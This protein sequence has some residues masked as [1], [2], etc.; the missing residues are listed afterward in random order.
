[1]SGIS[2]SPDRPASKRGPGILP[3]LLSPV[4]GQ[5]VKGGN[6]SGGG[7]QPA[8]H[9]PHCSSA[10][11]STLEQLSAHLHP[12]NCSEQYRPHLHQDAPGQA[13]Q[14]QEC[15]SL[16]GPLWRPTTD[17]H[18]APFVPLARADF[19]PN[20]GAYW[21]AA[22]SNLFHQLVGG[23]ARNQFRTTLEGNGGARRCKLLHWVQIITE[24]CC[25]SGPGAGECSAL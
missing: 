11:A 24:R 13:G 20:I 16:F 22:F 19:R 23:A 14:G 8:P 18:N 17:P 25:N 10:S 4:R 6:V 1:M 2:P 3:F 12:Q 9:L 5:S 7:R 15:L 21:S